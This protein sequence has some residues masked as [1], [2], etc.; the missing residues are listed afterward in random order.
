MTRAIRLSGHFVT[1]NSGENERAGR[2][3]HPLDDGILG[4]LAIEGFPADAESLG[5]FLPVSRIEVEDFDDMLPLNRLKTERRLLRLHPF[6]QFPG[7]A[8]FGNKIVF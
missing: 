3:P 5:G 7:Q 6:N 8:T 4:K 2:D 1:V